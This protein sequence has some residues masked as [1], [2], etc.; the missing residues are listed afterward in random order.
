AIGVAKLGLTAEPSPPASDAAVH[1]VHDPRYVAM[2]DRAGASGGGY[3]DAD[4]YITPESMVAARSA[5]GAVVEGVDRVLD[6]RAQPA[7]AVV[8]PPGHHAARARA[9]GFRLLNHVPN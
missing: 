5:A 2:L 1:R 3:L 8:R 7:L 4:T 9:M 6:G